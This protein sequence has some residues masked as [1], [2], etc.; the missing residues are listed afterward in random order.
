M[1]ESMSEIGEEEPK[2]SLG[3]CGEP[4]QRHGIE[5]LI[6]VHEECERKNGR[7]PDADEEPPQA[8]SALPMGLQKKGESEQ[9]SAHLS[10]WDRLARQLRPGQGQY[11]QDPPEKIA[12]AES[13]SAFAAEDPKPHPGRKGEEEGKDE[14]AKHH[15]DGQSVEVEGRWSSA[16]QIPRRAFAHQRG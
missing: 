13:H 15:H 4:K 3:H 1:G 6:H 14:I 2:Q 10:R 8:L 7:S 11:G 9:R 12:K 5:G 16:R